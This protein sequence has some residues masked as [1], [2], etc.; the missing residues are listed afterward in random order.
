M[1]NITGIIL[2]GG[3]G[4]RLGGVEKAFIKIGHQTLLQIKISSLK[5][6]IKELMVVTNSPELYKE[7]TEF[8][9][10]RDSIK[11][12]GPLMGLLS[13]LKHSNTKYNFLTAVDMPFFNQQLFDY[14]AGFIS[15][16]DVVI[17]ERKGILQPLFA[18]YS[19]N[20]IP[21]IEDSFNNGQRKIRG[22]LDRVKVKY[23]PDKEVASFDK[24]EK[25]FINI[26]TK[27]DLVSIQKVE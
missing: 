4:T 22:F 11:E 24:Q 26:N 3:K 6:Y 13:G 2:S 10:V 23:L 9:V 27:E 21:A 7:S 1:N 25:T 12:K 17:P 8:Q 15:E 20:C 5:K 16:F 14:L 18:Y 19:K